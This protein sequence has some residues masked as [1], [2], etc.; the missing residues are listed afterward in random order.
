MG[1]ERQGDTPGEEKVNWPLVKPESG[2]H[3]SVSQEELLQFAQK[4]LLCSVQRRVQH[5]KERMSL[6]GSLLPLPLPA[7]PAKVIL[8]RQKP[9]FPLRRC[10]FGSRPALGIPKIYW[11]RSSCCLLFFLW[12]SLSAMSDSLQPH[13]LQ[14]GRLPC[15]S[16]VPSICS[17]SCP[18]S[19]WCHPTISSSAAPFCFCLHSFPA[20]G[21]FPVSLLFTSDGQYIWASALASILPTNIQGWFPL[22][23]SG[24]ILQS[25]G[26]SRSLLQDCL[27]LVC[28]TRETSTAGHG[29]LK[30]NTPSFRLHSPDS[31]FG[32]EDSGNLLPKTQ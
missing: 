29:K 25:K 21:S 2:R 17:N 13:G 6:P 8:S 4:S 28:W 10:T 18:L 5:L 23:L 15:P 22:G 26:L 24:L 27:C 9:S 12:F 7:M 1:T 11:W 19:E 14:H 30:I 31:N 20:S 16:L 3:W 32:A